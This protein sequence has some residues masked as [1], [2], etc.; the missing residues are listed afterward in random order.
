MET[1]LWKNDKC[2]RGHVGYCHIE[3]HPCEIPGSQSK[4]GNR[5]STSF[6]LF[7]SKKHRT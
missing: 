2:K 6:F 3:L 4:G 5:T 7:K 1:E